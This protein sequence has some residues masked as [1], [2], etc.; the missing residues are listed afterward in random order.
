MTKKNMYKKSDRTFVNPYN[1]V[2]IDR[3]KIKQENIEE[4]YKDK[5]ELHTGYLDCVLVAKTPLAIP[6]LP[7][8]EE[9]GGESKHDFFSI[10]GNDQKNPMI[11]G[12]SLRGMIRSVYETIT[13]S[14]LSTMKPDTHLF[15]RAGAEKK[16]IYKPGIL[17]EKDGE[18]KLYTVEKI[19]KIPD[20]NAYKKGKKIKVK[21]KQSYRTEIENEVRCLVADDNTKFRMGDSVEPEIESGMYVSNL[22]FDNKSD[23]YVYVG[24]AFSNKK[25]ERVFKIGKEISD[26][27]EN[28]VKTA[29]QLLEE[30]LKV[31]RNTAINKM[32]PD[33]HTGYADY[34]YAKKEKK[35]I[36]I[37]Y[38]KDQK[39][40]KVKLSM[41]C[42]GRIGY[43]TTL[44]D[45][46][47]KKV[48]CQNRKKL[49]SA[50]NLF[51]M[52]KEEA[53]GGRVRITDARA[54]GKVK[55]QKNVKLK[56]L[57][58]PRYS[59]WPFYAKT[60]SFKYPT[61]YESPEVEIRGRKYYWHIPEAAH[62]KDIYRDLRKEEDINQ[63]MQSGYFDLAYTGSRF[64]FRIYYNEI[65][66]VQLDEL[67]WTLCLGENQLNGNLCHKLG[68]GKP[69]G[70]GSVKVCIIN[71]TERRLSPEYHLE[72]EN[73][74]EKL[75]GMLHKQYKSVTE[76]QRISDF[77]MMENRKVEYPM[78]LCPESKQESDR[79]KKNDLASHN[80]FSENKSS[81]NKK[82]KKVQCLPEILSDDPVLYYYEYV[83][84]SKLNS[85]RGNATQKEKNRK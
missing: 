41:A 71:Q 73:N 30:T 75:G 54:K 48:P 72:I 26:L 11:P 43:Y 51:G 69:L 37:W 56:T 23:Q 25:F 77:N 55:W 14:C 44:D 61:D 28:A 33:E 42:I 24:E 85:D 49:C 67:K 9:S 79:A 64:G 46:V 81:E 84:T 20:K 63:N 58:T 13:E 7:E 82:E 21:I 47:K 65:T 12:S 52:A 18:W 57:A 35:V 5:E 6:D 60:N 78:I 27:R 74:L 10:N 17:K 59:Y 4:T 8:R 19:Y 1:F 80:W 39:T 62:N 83:D 36:P 22:S 38:Q 32:Y 40:N 3:K 2:S 16:E 76:I 70:L 31:Y 68:R 50:C 66:T 15:S 34:E 45:L 53:V 29:M